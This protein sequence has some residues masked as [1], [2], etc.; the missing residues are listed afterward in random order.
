MNL[1]ALFVTSISSCRILFRLLGF[2]F[3]SFGCPVSSE[4]IALCFTV[5]QYIDC[6]CFLLGKYFCELKP[7]ISFC[8][9]RQ[10]TENTRC[11][12]Y[13]CVRFWQE[14]TCGGYD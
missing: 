13:V 3:G 9:I 12:F 5:W 8:L 2:G 7:T 10:W 14:R 4:V 11:N 6:L 1:F